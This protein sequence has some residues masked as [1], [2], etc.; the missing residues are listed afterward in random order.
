LVVGWA[1]LSL[2]TLIGSFLK[3]S[4]S[5]RSASAWRDLGTFG[6]WPSLFMYSQ[7]RCF[8]WLTALPVLRSIHSPTLRE[9]HIPPS[10]GSSFSAALSSSRWSALSSALSLAPGF[11]WRRSPRASG[12]SEL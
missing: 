12:P 6:L 5:R 11:R 2:K 10:G 1:S 7:P 8:F 9:F 3:A 4:C